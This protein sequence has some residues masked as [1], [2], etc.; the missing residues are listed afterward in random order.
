MQMQICNV[1]WLEMNVSN[2]LRVVS[3]ASMIQSKSLEHDVLNKA[4]K[5][6]PLSDSYPVYADT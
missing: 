1:C 2:L 3:A 4:I 5:K 6:V